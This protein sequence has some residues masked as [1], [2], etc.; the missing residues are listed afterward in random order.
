MIS[1]EGGRIFVGDVGRRTYEE[2]SILEKGRN[3]AWPLKEGPLCLPEKNCSNIRKYKIIHFMFFYKLYFIRV[4][5]I[6][7]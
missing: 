3:Y 7:N 6:R 2:I 1:V 5:S 4:I